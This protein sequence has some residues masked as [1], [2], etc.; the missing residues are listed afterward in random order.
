MSDASA[1]D[2]IG[3]IHG[4]ADKLTA[5]LA[6]LG[7]VR[8]GVTWRHPERRAL[9]VGD[10]IDRGPSQLA[11]VETVRRMVDAGTALAVMG[12]HEFNAIAW[13]TPDP[14]APGTYL[15]PHDGAVGA[16][17]R[18]QH[19]AFL[20][21]VQAQPA[22]HREL[23]DWFMTLPLWLELPGLRVVHAC[24]HPAMM[25]RLRPCLAPGE[26]LTPALL[27]Q[28]SRK[29]SAE[30][31]ALETLLKGEEIALPAGLS[32]LDKDGHERH[33]VRTR[34]W[35][36]D[37]SSMAELAMGV[38]DAAL[39]PLRDVP[40][41][42]GLLRPESA[43]PTFFGHY[44]M[45]GAPRLHSPHMACVDYSAGKGGALVAYRW[46]GEAVLDARHFVAVG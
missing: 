18:H 26:R 43:V 33:E 24:W 31:Q 25:A 9:F 8:A 36:P 40:V 41:P 11:V 7:Y 14:D 45:S 27:V 4:Q 30:Y 16:K 23:I 38:P 20:A 15:R 44:W 3:D 12:N 6:T 5:L 39:P 10:F 13:A 42:P 22:R 19:A 37:P 28:G 34:W 35:L 32:F 1:F 29:G 2:I 17:N 46:S 21:E